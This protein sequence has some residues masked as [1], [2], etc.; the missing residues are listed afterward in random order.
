MVFINFYVFQSPRVNLF[1]FS[2][3]TFCTFFIPYATNL[4]SQL[5]NIDPR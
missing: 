2:G 5:M 1:Y 3:I 4:S